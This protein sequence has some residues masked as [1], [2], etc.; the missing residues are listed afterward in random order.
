MS[1]DAGEKLMNLDEL[2]Q[3][4]R[5]SVEPHVT[6]LPAPQC[7]Y[8]LFFSI[9]DGTKR[10]RVCHVVAPHIDAAWVQAAEA[11]HRLAQQHRIEV[12]WL[13]VDWV[14]R[15]E[16]LSWGA[17]AGRL[18]NTKRNYFRQGIA[19]D[20]GLTV[21]YL[22][23]ELNA[24][25]ML[26]AG[27]NIPHAQINPNN[28]AVYGKIRFGQT[29]S[30]DFEETSIVQVFDTDGVFCDAE[31]EV[32]RLAGTERDKGRRSVARLDVRTVEQLIESGSDFLARQVAEDGKF[33]YGLFPCFDREVPTY[34]ALRHASS[35][36][37]ML[38]A[39]E[40]TRSPRLMEAIQR[41]LDFLTRELIR[42][43]DVGNGVQEA[44][45][46]DVGNEIKLGGNAV[47][48]LALV[49]YTELTGDPRYLPLLEHLALGI[50]RM[51]DAE[52]GAFVHVLSFPCLSVKQR[53]RIIYYDGEA[54]FGLMRLYGLTRDVRW[55]RM[56]ERAFEYFIA[57]KHWK[58]HDHW[59]SYCVNELTRYSADERY[60]RFGLQN[61][62]GYLDFV[63][64]RITTFPTLL[65]LMMAAEQMIERLLG[66]PAGKALLAN[67]DYDKFYRALNVRAHHL[68]NGYFWPEVAMYFRNPQRIV[69]SFFIRH[70]AFRVRID[71]VEH[72]LSG[73][74]AY[75]GFLARQPLAAGQKALVTR[76]D[77]VDGLPGVVQYRGGP[78]WTQQRI[79]HATGGRWLIRPK[80]NKW[81]S[82]GLCIW[83]PSMQA[84]EMVVVRTSAWAG[85]VSPPA[86]RHL[87]F[88]PQAFIIDEVGSELPAGIPVL[89]V[90]NARSAVL[91]VGR[92]SRAQME[93]K[94][95]GVTG[96][97]GKTTTTSMLTH[98]LQP[99]GKIGCTRHNANLPHGIAWNLASIPW[100]SRFVVLEM[101]I[102]RM[103]QNTEM[104]RPNVAVFTNIAPAHLEYHGTTAVI[105]EKKS[106]IFEGMPDDG[107]VVLNRDMDEWHI[108][109][110]AASCRDLKVIHFG[111]HVDCDVRILAYD[112]PRAAVRLA[113]RGREVEYRL[114][115]PG[116]HMAF[117]SAACV[118]T[119]LALNL[120]IEPMLTQF[121]LFRA[122]AGRGEILDVQIGQQR[123]R[124][125]DEAY[126][127]NPESMRAALRLAAELEPAY[128]GGRRVF[129]L[130]DMR[131]LGK[132]SA[133]LHASLADD[134]RAAAPDLVLLCGAEMRHLFNALAL[135]SSVWFE[136]LG[137]LRNALTQ[138]L[139]HGD[140]VLIKSSAGSGLSE[141]VSMLQEMSS[142]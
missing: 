64:E 127:A 92:F 47:C 55:L 78:N 96:S 136:D 29:P 21:A 137:Q 111:T 2:L 104:A 83:A 51:Q 46:V 89:Q 114:G 103:R 138:H 27:S 56:V 126:N 18:K 85:G 130:G 60:F 22:E 124:V 59:L 105:A 12:K 76:P 133:V 84:G 48:L 120:D 33:I 7:A 53:F 118:A 10:A 41:G 139:N 34:N 5:P 70:H 94:L 116:L 11:L 82:T 125:V 69:G 112:A 117:N 93:G 81:C 88:F 16:P 100:D 3:A 9:C 32:L 39:W 72:Y 54:A 65:E 6:A 80:T 77:N 45:L 8:V 43:V 97:A 132:S 75:R 141:L 106:R 37:A 142:A 98:A 102:G 58:A 13:R 68:L 121:A 19:L 40:V 31:G 62:E 49:K 26:Y 30:L 63:L 123:L 1:G 135:P 42:I 4:V 71:D 79:E 61:I 119:A 44:F 66:M 140:L 35:L 17:L 20:E 74:V 23:Q 28:F 67:F 113:V 24:N 87:P 14:T 52:S 57:Q 101:A 36:Y 50:A 108:V 25:A 134:V 129:V 122:C 86:L 95:I 131:E 115:A 99:W 73:F 15:V 128:A 107:V 90:S 38:E 110:R 109:H 91:E